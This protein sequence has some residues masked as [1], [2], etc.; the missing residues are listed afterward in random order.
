MQ[1]QPNIPNVLGER[2]PMGLIK[3]K[4]EL[5]QKEGNGH[6]VEFDLVRKIMDKGKHARSQV[7]ENLLKKTY[8]VGRRLFNAEIGRAVVNGDYCFQG[9]DFDIFT[10][11]GFCRHHGQSQIKEPLRLVEREEEQMEFNAMIRAAENDLYDIFAS[12]MTL[13]RTK[14]TIYEVSLYSNDNAEGLTLEEQMASGK[15]A[16]TF[17]IRMIS[18]YE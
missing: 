9:I 18:Q 6:N 7:I 11:L 12:A 15:E 1:Q 8:E 3:F 5:F 16:F 17:V 14:L 13:N 10:K 4:F 2:N